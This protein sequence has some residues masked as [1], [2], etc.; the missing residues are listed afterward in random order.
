MNQLFI[1]RSHFRLLCFIDDVNHLTFL[2]KSHSSLSLSLSFSVS[3][4]LHFC[5]GEAD[6]RHGEAEVVG[7]TGTGWIEA[8]VQFVAAEL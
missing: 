8:G 2:L 1:T 4:S 3:L 6:H 5:R 7:V